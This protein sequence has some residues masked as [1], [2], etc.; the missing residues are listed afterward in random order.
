M[1]NQ[2]KNLLK[3]QT[4]CTECIALFLKKDIRIVQPITQQDLD[5]GRP[6]RKSF[7]IDDTLKGHSSLVTFLEDDKK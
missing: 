3:L 5:K 7:K 2:I 1:N 4:K 6:Y